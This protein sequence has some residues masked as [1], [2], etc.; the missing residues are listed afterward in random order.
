[1][2]E[3]AKTK[4]QPLLEMEGFRTRPDAT[5]RRLQEDSEILQV[6]IDERNRAEEIFAKPQEY[7]ES[8]METTREPGY[9][10]YPRPESHLSESFLL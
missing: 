6:Q 3:D 1:M 9:H 5:E 2:K 7:T 4:L 10:A 8:I